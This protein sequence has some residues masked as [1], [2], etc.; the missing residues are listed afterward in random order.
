MGE[1]SLVQC[2]RARQLTQP[3]AAD[4]NER[5]EK[6]SSC[7]A[8]FLAGRRSTV[9][10]FLS[11]TTQK[12]DKKQRRCCWCPRTKAQKRL[13]TRLDLTQFRVAD[14]KSPDFFQTQRLDAFWLRK[15]VAIKSR[16]RQIAVPRQRRSRHLGFARSLG[17]QVPKLTVWFSY[18]NR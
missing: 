8:K 15:V 5:I 10:S 12:K 17:H 6:N 16:V 1:G 3:S 13:P 2:M 7:D 18:P 14:K 9:A 4:L 11:F